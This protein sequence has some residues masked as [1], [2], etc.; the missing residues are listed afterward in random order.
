MFLLIKNVVAL[1]ILLNMQSPQIEV[2][3]S[4]ND[5]AKGIQLYNNHNLN[6]AKKILENF[7][8]D[9]PDNAIGFY[10]LGRVH[11]DE[12]NYKK[13]E[14]WF[15]KAIE[16][17]ANNSIYHT[18]LGNTYGNKINNASIFKK[19]GLAKK[20]KKHY[21][22]ALKLDESNPDAREG[23]ITFYREAPGIMGGSTEKAKQHAEVLKGLDKYRGYRA[24]WRIYEKEK[25]YDQAEDTYKIALE[26]FPE[27]LNLRFQFGYFYQRREKYPEAFELFEQIVRDSTDNMGAIYQIGRTGSLSGRNLDRAEECFKQYLQ[28]EPGE[29]MPS[30]AAAHWRLGMVYEHKN[31][32]D[33]AKKEYQ[34]ALELEPDL[35]AAKKALKKL[36]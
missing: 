17:D 24:L 1:S 28:H 20:I 29:N 14:K 6:E 36:K 30:L 26:E 4:D 3:N 23:L 34:A 15:K 9:Y 22:I 25:K 33:L 16:L 27:N 12:N 35:K 21:E 19:P 13:S 31:E 10:Y 32:R 18:W 7:V 11:F 8:K 5:L 2:I